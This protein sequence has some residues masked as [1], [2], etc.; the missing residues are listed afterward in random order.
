MTVARPAAALCTPGRVAVT[1]IRSFVNA[2]LTV[3][4][5]HHE[6]RCADESGA[7]DARGISALTAVR[8]RFAAACGSPARSVRGRRSTTDALFRSQSARC[9]TVRSSY[10]ERAA[11][12]TGPRPT[13]PRSVPAR[14]GT[15]HRGPDR[16]RLRRDLHGTYRDECPPCDPARW[17]RSRAGVGASLGVVHERQLACLG[18]SGDQDIAGTDGRPFR[19]EMRSEL[20]GLFAR[21]A[22]SG[23]GTAT[24]PTCATAA[25]QN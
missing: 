20:P 11:T 3:V 8:T 13:A 24:W 2:G 5:Q 1:F 16:R 12:E 14:G 6:R 10:V 25:R 18:R 21:L 19:C 4:R 22:V 9:R 17:S 15:L 7:A 23:L